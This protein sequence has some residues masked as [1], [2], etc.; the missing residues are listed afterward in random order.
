MLV[1]IRPSG[2]IA[3]IAVQQL[4]IVGLF[5]GIVR[6]QEKLERHRRG[7]KIRSVVGNAD[8]GLPVHGN[9]DGNADSRSTEPRCGPTASRAGQRDAASGARVLTGVKG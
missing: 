3:V 9:A 8:L 5:W 7:D 4:A 1:G 2:Y 6:L